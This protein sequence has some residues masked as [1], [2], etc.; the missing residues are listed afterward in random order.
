MIKLNFYL[1]SDK[2]N[3][4]N[5]YPIFLKLTYQGKSTTVST[6]KWLAKERWK[7]TNKLKNPLK[8]KSEKNCKL[9]MDRMSGRIEEIYYE[10]IKTTANLTVL[11][12]KNSYTGKTGKMKDLDVLFLFKIHNE[13]FKKK[14]KY[15]EKSGRQA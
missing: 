8:I 3:A 5:E 2:V 13:N 9:A 15:D 6:G 1:K 12:I 10:L 7:F 11:E 4:L 14:V